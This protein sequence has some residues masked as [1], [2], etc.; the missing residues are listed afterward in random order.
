MTKSPL[1]KSIKITASALILLTAIFSTGIGAAFADPQTILIPGNFTFQTNMS[2]GN[3]KTPDVSYLQRF[4]NYDPRTRLADADPCVA[5]PLANLYDARTRDAVI[6]F[7]N[8]Y[9]AETLTPAGLSTGSGVAGVYTRNKINQLLKTADY[10]PI[11]DKLIASSSVQI[12]Q[13]AQ[14]S[15]V[16]NYY[17]TILNVLN[18]GPS[19][20]TGPSTQSQLT[21]SSVAGNNYFTYLNQTVTGQPATKPATSTYDAATGVTTPLV[22]TSAPAPTSTYPIINSYY[23]Q[24]NQG[25]NAQPTAS[26]PR[27]GTATPAGASTSQAVNDYFNYIN[28]ILG[29]G[30]PAPLS[31]SSALTSTNPVIANYYDQINKATN[32][33]LPVNIAPVSTVPGVVTKPVLVSVTPQALVHCLI[34]IT[35]VGQNFSPTDNTLVGTLGYM[36]A[37][38]TPY[39]VQYDPMTGLPQT[40][41]STPLRAIT[42]NIKQFS[43]YNAVQ[44]LYAGTTQPITIRV[45]NNNTGEISET[46]AVVEYTF[47]GERN[48]ILWPKVDESG[49]PVEEAAAEA[50]AEAAPAESGA[51]S[52]AK[53]NQTTPTG[54]LKTIETVDKKLISMTPRGK[55]L[56]LIGGDRAVDT[57]Y[58]LTPN[59]HLN[60]KLQ[61]NA[62][63]LVSMLG[64]GGKAKNGS[65]GGGS[66]TN[67]TGAAAGLGLAVGAGALASWLG[68]DSASKQFNGNQN[69]SV[70]TDNFGGVIT[71]T[72]KCT[73]SGQTLVT[74]QE[75]RGGSVQ[76][77][78]QDGVTINYDHKNVN[79]GANTLGTYVQ[80]GQ[81]MVYDGTECDATGS[82]RGTMTQIGTSKAADTSTGAQGGTNGATQP[83]PSGS[84]DGNNLGGGLFGG[85]G[86]K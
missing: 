25:T 67:L 58:G 82:P 32:T 4:L 73:C 51:A 61:G 37:S 66:G 76:L 40:A 39:L 17:S 75:A 68:S 19:P 23:T 28:K 3:T 55:I 8:L 41:S 59:G 77:L 10:A 78:F 74:I 86:P 53:K 24:V 5:P 46:A 1:T 29:G 30:A 27:T 69:Q 70:P 80:G 34:T 47:P 21:S 44:S 15:V 7:Q 84:S 36:Y 56:K 48:T 6:K 49:Y 72:Q 54:I 57:F 9:K 64:K 13:S 43:D 81:C 38:S 20:M 63:G 35:I 62:P 42:F 33:A 18:G 50:P 65:A 16:V 85:M 52:G 71:A 26:T 79:P 60:Q 2:L 31:T 22:V 45:Q 11:V 12:A 83:L 14:E